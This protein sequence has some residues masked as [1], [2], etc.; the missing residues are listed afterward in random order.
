VLPQP[1]PARR[2]LPSRGAQRRHDRRLPR[3]RGGE[4]RPAGDGGGRVTTALGLL[5][6]VGSLDWDAIRGDLDDTGVASAGLVLPP[7]EAACIRDLY[8]DGRRFRKT[9]DM[10]R[11]RFGRGEYRY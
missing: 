6:R 5:D 4:G 8:A 2:A 7:S 10:E 9:I 1:G 11:H 3:G